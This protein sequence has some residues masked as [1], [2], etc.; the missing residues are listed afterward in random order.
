MDL[1]RRSRNKWADFCATYGTLR[2]IEDAY[3]A[4]DLFLPPQWQPPSS[5][6]RR[7]LVASI[8]NPLDHADAGVQQ[9]LLA[10]YLDGIDDWGR[11]VSTFMPA[12]YDDVL[13]PEARVL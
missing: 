2:S 12:D 8:E 9:R 13:V 6:Q 3:A 10:T 7:A 1:T 11:A 5:S 4:H